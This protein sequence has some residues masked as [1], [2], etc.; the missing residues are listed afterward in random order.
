MSKGVVQD[1][2]PGKIPTAFDIGLDF[3]IHNRLQ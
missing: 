2:I 3:F 1:D